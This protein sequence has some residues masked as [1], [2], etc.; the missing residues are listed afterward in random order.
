GQSETD[1]ASSDGVWY[2]H[3]GAVNQ[4]GTWSPTS[5][6]KVMIDST[7]PLLS[8]ASSTQ[9]NQGAW[10][11]TNSGTVNATA[12]A[13]SGVTG[14]AYSIDQT[15][16]GD[17]GT[18]ATTTSP[19]YSY[20]GLANGTWYVHARAFGGSGLASAVK[21]YALH[22]DTAVPQAPVLSASVPAATWTA[23][24]SVTFGWTPPTSASGVAGYAV[25]F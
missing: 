23:T 22:V 12:S 25:S 24:R 17:P 5:T 21:T 16:N 9:P 3:V 13:L 6:Y 20:S 14:Y 2:F 18:S 15:A 19:S 4:A 8:L 7:A 10:Y 1:T 11:N